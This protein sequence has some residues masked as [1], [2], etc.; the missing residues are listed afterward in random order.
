LFFGA[1]VVSQKHNGSHFSRII[2]PA[3]QYVYAAC[4]T[5]GSLNY[6]FTRSVIEEVE[7]QWFNGLA[8]LRLSVLGRMRHR[9]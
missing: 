8:R 6:V 1:Q 9:V 2:D 4:S 5:R 3:T 7:R